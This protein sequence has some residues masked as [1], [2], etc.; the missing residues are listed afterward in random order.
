ME[1][2]Y[3][4]LYRSLKDS[5]MWY[6]ERFTRSQAWID[7]LMRANHKD[8]SILYEYNKYLIPMGSFVTSQRK[9]SEDW[10]WSISTV[11]LFLDFLVSRTQI[12]RTIERRFTHI[13]I[14]NWTK[15]QNSPYEIER[16][17]EEKSNA[18]RTLIETNNNNKN[19]KKYKKEE[20]SKYITPP[21]TD[22]QKIVNYYKCSKGV[23]LDDKSW[24]KINY[25]RYSKSAKNLIEILGNIEEVNM[26]IGEIKKRMD[27][28]GLSWT[29]ETVAKWAH[30][31]KIEIKNK[32]IKEK[33]RI[34]IEQS[35]QRAIAESN[36]KSE[37]Y[38]N[39]IKDL[40]KAKTIGGKNELPDKL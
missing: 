32:E 34:T 22:I 12:E 8:G 5:D 35:A 2:G 6:S 11:S 40:A 37:D 36:Y 31:Y 29:L 24:D 38:K 7:M 9:L 23:P 15:Y 27:N 30:D 19:D 21:E 18:N 25:A 33:P 1:C 16:T 13:Y 39:M 28:S 4:K 3:I 10:K 14:V 17:I 26:C 20:E